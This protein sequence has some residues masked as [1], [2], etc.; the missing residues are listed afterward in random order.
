M[1]CF[2]IKTSLVVLL[3]ILIAYVQSYFLHAQT[4]IYIVNDKGELELITAEYL[5]FLRY[6]QGIRKTSNRRIKDNDEAYLQKMSQALHSETELRRQVQEMESQKF[7]VGGDLSEEKR[8]LTLAPERLQQELQDLKLQE[9]NVENAS[10]KVQR[11]EATQKYLVKSTAAE[12]G[13]RKYTI[14]G[15]KAGC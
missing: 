4:K 1:G 15:E 9:R 5:H 6:V 12:G 2:R 3:M 10:L 14:G 11:L 7:L 13:R 8:L